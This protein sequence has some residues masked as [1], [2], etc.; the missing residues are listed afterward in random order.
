METFAAIV[1]AWIAIA[2]K[3]EASQKTCFLW[4]KNNLG[5][6]R[7]IKWYFAYILNLESLGR[8]IGKK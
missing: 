7:L 6:T 4:G 8:E 2:N 5:L 3:M 1:E